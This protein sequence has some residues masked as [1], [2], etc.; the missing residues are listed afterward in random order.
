[1]SDEGRALPMRK[2]ITTEDI[3]PRTL[4]KIME[5]SARV[6]EPEMARTNEEI[7]AS[8][9]TAEELGQAEESV[10]HRLTRAYLNGYSKG[11]HEGRNAGRLDR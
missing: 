5:S 3:P 6:K 10:E 11:F 9:P 4:D 8:L 1:M 7:Y 2:P